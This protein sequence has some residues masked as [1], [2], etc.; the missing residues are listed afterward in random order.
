[1]PDF[2][3]DIG[4]LDALKKNINRSADNVDDCTKRLANLAP[5]SVG[6]D[7]LDQACADFREY[8]KEGLEEIREAA[9]DI[10]KGIDKAAQGYR[11]TEE[12]IRDAMKKMEAEL[13]RGKAGNR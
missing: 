3:V 9:K 10:A 4:G 11:D 13:D 2:T 6:S 5:D 8:W 12:G 1:M 7:D